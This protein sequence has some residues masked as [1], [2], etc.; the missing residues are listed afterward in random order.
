MTLKFKFFKTL[1]YWTDAFFHLSSLEL[2]RKFWQT[3]A[4]F[5]FYNWFYTF[6]V[7]ISC[8]TLGF[9]E[10]LL[11]FWPN[12][13]A[14]AKQP[15]FLLKLCIGQSVGLFY[16]FQNQTIKI[17]I[18]RVDP[19]YSNQTYSKQKNRIQSKWKFVFSVELRG[20]YAV[21]ETKEVPDE[22]G[23]MDEGEPKTT[24]SSKWQ[25]HSLKITEGDIT[26]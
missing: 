18:S 12:F 17:V 6:L 10:E 21:T 5:Y 4:S 2:Q 11:N 3:V 1:P 20:K 22:V 26:V 19:S 9:Y 15:S 14:K 16:T 8:L 25:V 13:Q 7:K 24:R 23:L